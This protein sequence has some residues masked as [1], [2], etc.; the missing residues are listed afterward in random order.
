[1]CVIFEPKMSNRNMTLNTKKHQVPIKIK[2]KSTGSISQSTY[3]NLL[4]MIREFELVYNLSPELD[5]TDKQHLLEEV[6]RIFDSERS[7]D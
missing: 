3:R 2:P 5:E 6:S 4:L 1:L 7:S